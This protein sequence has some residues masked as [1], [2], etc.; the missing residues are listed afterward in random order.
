M[1][2]QPWNN[3][4]HCTA[5]TYGT[6]LR[7]DPR[8]WRSQNHREHVEGDYKNP[9]PS[10]TFDAIHARS[11]RLMKRDPMHLHRA[12][13]S[14]ALAAI[15]EKLLEKEIPIAAAALDDHHLHVVMQC[16]DR[17]P[18]HWIGLAKKNSAWALKDA[19]LVP[20]GGVW[21]KRGLCKPITDQSHFHRAINYVKDHAKRGA[22]IWT[23]ADSL[24]APTR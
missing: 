13:Q 6:W 24:V 1:S 2:V 22:W 17:N 11:Q 14:V 9:P 12:M 7:G 3:W 5:S 10:G 19:E 4:F 20:P 16:V 18:R 15:I 8:G 23:P 21:A